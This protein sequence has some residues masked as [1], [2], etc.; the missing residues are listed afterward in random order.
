[1]AGRLLCPPGLRVTGVTWFN[2]GCY[3]VFVGFT[4]RP[5]S[6]E[7]VQRF[8][9]VE[10]DGNVAPTGG[11]CCHKMTRAGMMVLIISMIDKRWPKNE[12][13]AIIAHEAT[14]AT[15]F[16]MEK[17]GEEYPGF[18]Q[19]AYLVQQIVQDCLYAL[20]AHWRDRDGRKV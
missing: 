1:M 17:I 16:I 10:A 2:M 20:D 15:R 9:G 18:E 11:A 13:A 19:E 14:H 7:R 5:S 3:P 4:M 8:M 6:L 12:T